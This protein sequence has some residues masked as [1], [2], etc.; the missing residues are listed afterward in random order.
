MQQTHMFP[1]IQEELGRI[2]NGYIPLI[3]VVP[4]LLGTRAGV[5]GALVLAEQAAGASQSFC[6]PNPFPSV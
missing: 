6:E 4:P 5:L 3:E 2:L 1:L